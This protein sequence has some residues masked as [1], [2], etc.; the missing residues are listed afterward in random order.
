MQETPPTNEKTYVKVTDVSS[1]REGDV[2]VLGC[3][4]QSAIAGP[5]GTGAFLSKVDMEISDGQ[6][7]AEEAFEI[8]LGGKEDAWTLTTSE[9]QITAS[10]EKAFVLNNGNQKTCTISISGGVA[11]ITF[12]SYGS[13]QYNAGTPRFLNYKSSQTGIEIYKLVTAD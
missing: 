3:A 13:I 8:T 4:A 7:S 1:L 2:I 5:M 10:K 6:F 12:G 11:T 9:G